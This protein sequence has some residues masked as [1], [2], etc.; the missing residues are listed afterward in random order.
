MP[1][2]HATGYPPQLVMPPTI[3]A[4]GITTDFGDLDFPDFGLPRLNAAGAGLE[5]ATNRAVGVGGIGGGGGI[6]FPGDPVPAGGWLV[7]ALLSTVVPDTFAEDGSFAEGASDR[8]LFS[9]LD[10]GL[11][12]AVGPI[13][14]RVGVGVSVV[15]LVVTSQVEDGPVS[16]SWGTEECL[17]RGRVIEG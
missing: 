7:G 3:G 8:G 10:R 14:E 9:A 1:P 17:S 11:F 6:F 12:S 2:T 15:I 16:Y 13:G 4:T 5:T